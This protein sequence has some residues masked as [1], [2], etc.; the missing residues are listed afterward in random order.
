MTTGEIVVQK[1]QRYHDYLGHEFVSHNV[2]LPI[3][4]RGKIVGVVELAKDVEPLENVD[5]E[6]SD[7][8][9]NEFLETL[10]RESGYITFSLIQK[11]ARTSIWQGRWQSCRI[12]RSFTERPERGR[13][14]LR[15]R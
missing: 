5:S 14:C 13:N 2:T 11:C 6:E 9:F 8:I 1:N 10:Q 15:K 7:V 4:R 12:Q 3:R